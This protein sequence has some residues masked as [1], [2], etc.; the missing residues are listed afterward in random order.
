MKNNLLYLFAELLTPSNKL[1][2]Q[3]TQT[4]GNYWRCYRYHPESVPQQ[5]RIRNEFWQFMTSSITLQTRNRLYAWVHIL[6]GFKLLKPHF[7][8]SINGFWR[9]IFAILNKVIAIYAIVRVS[10]YLLFTLRRT[11]KKNEPFLLLSS[12]VKCHFI[13]NWHECYDTIRHAI[14][15]KIPNVVV[16]D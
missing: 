8:Y 9:Q 11:H 1:S 3:N 12:G 15:S 4:E 10:E 13:Q 2:S 16:F 7:H 5:Y 6:N 14:L